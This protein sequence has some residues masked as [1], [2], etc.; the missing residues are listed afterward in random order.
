MN[1]SRPQCWVWWASLSWDIPEKTSSLKLVPN[2]DFYLKGYPSTTFR[3]KHIP[4]FSRIS[5]DIPGYPDLSQGPG[6]SRD[7]P[8]Y[9]DL[10]HGVRIPDEKT[11]IIV[12]HWVVVTECQGR[13]RPGPGVRAA[14]P[15]TASFS[16]FFFSQC[17][18]IAGNHVTH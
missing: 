15:P 17:S 14:Q 12:W 13:R 1:L 18:G 5:R 8:T 3:L 10:Y 4:K 16:T 7:I 2:M 6:I 9:P 11:K